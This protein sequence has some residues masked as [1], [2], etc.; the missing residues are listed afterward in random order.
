MDDQKKFPVTVLNGYLGFGKTTVLMERLAKEQRSISMNRSE[1]TDEL[2]NC[3]L[4]SEEMAM[5]WSDFP[6]EFPDHSGV[7]LEEP[8]Q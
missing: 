8:L 4:T 5:D 6:D 7:Q 2:D 3:L 1:I